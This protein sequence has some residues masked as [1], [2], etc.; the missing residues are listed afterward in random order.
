M[1]IKAYCF[2]SRLHVFLM[3]HVFC[4]GFA[5]ANEGRRFQFLLVFLLALLACQ[6][7]NGS[8]E[9]QETSQ[10]GKHH[11]GSGLQPNGFLLRVVMPGATSSVLAPSSDGF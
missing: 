1:F 3:F 11:F 9:M 8:K 5:F 10:K 4:Q 7:S 2:W 6:V